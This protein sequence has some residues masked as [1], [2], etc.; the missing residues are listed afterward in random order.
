MKNVPFRPISAKN[1]SKMIKTRSKLLKTAKR[2]KMM[3]LLTSQTFT[4]ISSVKGEKKQTQFKPNGLR[5]S[6]P[7]ALGGDPEKQIMQNK[8]NVNI[9]NIQ[10]SF[11]F[12]LSQ[13]YA[14]H[15]RTRSIGEPNPE[16]P[17]SS[18]SKIHIPSGD[19]IPQSTR[20]R[21]E[22]AKQ[23]EWNLHS[24]YGQPCPHKTQLCKTNPMPKAHPRW[25][26][27][28]NIANMHK[29]ITPCPPLHPLVQIA[30]NKANFKKRRN[31]TSVF[32]KETYANTHPLEETKKQ[33]VP[34]QLAPQGRETQFEKANL[35]CHIAHLSPTTHSINR[36]HMSDKI[37]GTR[38][39][40][41]L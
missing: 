39:N 17:D 38:H 2:Q 40:T 11:T 22:Q 14:K 26:T 27:L 32:T 12:L 8:P 19:T 10:Y 1:R 23:V 3:Q 35:L 34:I 24:D 37:Q 36:P 41:Q 28:G 29:P 18:G 5:L 31:D 7:H 33:L 20:R 6:S 15:R 13:K 25:I 30:Q 21:P 16:G 4:S 9:G